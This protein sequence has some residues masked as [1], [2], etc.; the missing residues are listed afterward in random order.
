M[1]GCEEEVEQQEFQFCIKPEKMPAFTA[2]QSLE[3]IDHAF[4]SMSPEGNDGSIMSRVVF[5]Y[6]GTMQRAGVRI[7]PLDGSQIQ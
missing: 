7:K 2:R 4:G 5:I 1:I 3:R 6:S